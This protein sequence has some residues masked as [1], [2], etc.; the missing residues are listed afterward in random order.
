MNQVYNGFF[1]VN[2]E[3]SQK[4]LFTVIYKFLIVLIFWKL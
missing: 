1:F 2:D 4:N 3:Y